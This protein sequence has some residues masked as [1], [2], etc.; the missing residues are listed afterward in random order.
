MVKCAG[1]SAQQTVVLFDYGEVTC[2]LHLVL[3]GR[4]VV[5]AALHNRNSS[6]AV[7]FKIQLME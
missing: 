3:R 6:W 7:A 2:N 4:L 1:C 5:K